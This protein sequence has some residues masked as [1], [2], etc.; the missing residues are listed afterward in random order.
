MSQKEKHVFFLFLR[1]IRSGLD[2]ST[3]IFR[4]NSG[5][6][7]EKMFEILYVLVQNSD[8]C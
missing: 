3:F 5:L 4:K 7:P 8:N 2:F 6:N 1:L